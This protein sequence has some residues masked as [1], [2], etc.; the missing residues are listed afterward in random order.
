VVHREPGISVIVPAHDE[1]D[2]IGLC[3]CSVLAQDYEGCLEVVVVANGC[4]DATAARARSFGMQMRGRGWRLHVIEIPRASKPRALNLGD[5]TA[6]FGHRL[7]V[8]A[9]IELSPTSLADVACA[10]ERGVRFCAPR[11]NAVGRSYSSRVYG[12]VWSQLPYVR[13]EVIGAGVYGVSSAGRRRWGGFP[14]IVADDKFARLHFTAG[15]RQVLT[16]SSFDVHLPYGFRELVRVRSRWIRANAELRAE[17]PL[18]AAADKRR[19]DRL[20]PF[21]ARHPRL[22]PDMAC[23]LLIYTCADARA[24]VIRRRH[25]R[26]PAW[27]RASRARKLRARPDQV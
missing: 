23:F 5:N 15:E 25:E 3:L 2:T 4:A 13:G 20:I 1:E 27:E 7:Y 26:H 6:G 22:W 19:L 14:D 12:R 10:F 11:L 9:D 16:T 8:D 17:F 18:L 21:I 24:L